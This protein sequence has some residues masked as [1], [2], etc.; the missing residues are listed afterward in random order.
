MKKQDLTGVV[1]TWLDET[2]GWNINWR[3]QHSLAFGPHSL[4]LGKLVPYFPPVLVSIAT[5]VNVPL[6][7]LFSM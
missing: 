6:P 3:K 1:N 4:L 5:I 7:F 2:L